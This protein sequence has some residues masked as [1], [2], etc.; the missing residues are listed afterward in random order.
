VNR[1][2]KTTGQSRLLLHQYHDFGI[3]SKVPALCDR[4]CRLRASLPAH[5]LTPRLWSYF[6]SASQRFLSSQLHIPWAA[7]TQPPG[8]DIHI[9]PHRASVSLAFNVSL[10]MAEATASQACCPPKMTVATIES[11]LEGRLVA[12]ILSHPVYWCLF[13]LSTMSH[14]LTQ[15]GLLDLRWPSWSF[16]FSF[17]SLLAT[18]WRPLSVLRPIFFSIILANTSPCYA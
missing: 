7:K 8:W 6:T 18:F 4:A 9:S 13:C 17:G 10:R 14:H 3:F 5:P 1:K 12:N 2:S 15:N 16:W 11:D